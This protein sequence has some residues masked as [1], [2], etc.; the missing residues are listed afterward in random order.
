MYA[1]IT[2]DD[3]TC[4]VLS[5]HHNLISQNACTFSSKGIDFTLLD[6]M[7]E[8]VLVRG[9]VTTRFKQENDRTDIGFET[10][11]DL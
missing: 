3:D 2:Q 7:V 11:I 8:S 4:F 5:L 9:T 6:A 10:S 1:S